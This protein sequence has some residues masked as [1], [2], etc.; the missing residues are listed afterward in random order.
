MSDSPYNYV[1]STDSKLKSLVGYMKR[2]IE[3]DS[4]MAF[5]SLYA[6][7]LADQHQ[8]KVFTACRFYQRA[9]GCAVLYMTYSLYET[10]VLRNTLRRGSDHQALCARLCD[11]IIQVTDLASRKQPIPQALAELFLLD[12]IAVQVMTAQLRTYPE[13]PR[14]DMRLTLPVMF[15][16][17]TPHTGQPHPVDAVHFSQVTATLEWLVTACLATLEIEDA[18]ALALVQDA[19]VSAHR[20]RGEPLGRAA[21]DVLMHLAV[22]IKLALEFGFVRIPWAYAH[23]LYQSMLGFRS[24]RVLTQ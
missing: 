5:S 3:P 19:W 15:G 13:P 4:P 6:Q 20:Q 1:N 23:G 17:P 18:D 9:C 2:M 8:H 22:T 21:I 14:A 24:A 12:S 11:V 10:F 16:L 7:R